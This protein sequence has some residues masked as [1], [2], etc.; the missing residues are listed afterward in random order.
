MMRFHDLRHT[1]ATLL[2]GR[3]MHQKLVAA[4]LGH[5]STAMV[6]EVYSHVTPSIQAQAVAELEALFGDTVGSILTSNG[7]ERG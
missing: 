6:N 4:I 2:L 3:G 5:S 1:T 7:G